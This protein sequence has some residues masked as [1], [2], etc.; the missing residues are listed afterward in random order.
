LW[1]LRGNN[2]TKK[3]K[4]HKH[5]W[6]TIRAVEGKGRREERGEDKKE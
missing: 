3:H 1:K 5:E 6:G 4:G 2:K